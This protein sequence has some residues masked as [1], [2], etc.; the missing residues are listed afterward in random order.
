MVD[1]TP[2]IERVQP[3][4]TQ[5]SYKQTSPFKFWANKVIPLVYDDSL[6]YYEV[7]CKLTDYLNVVIDVVTDEERNIG[8]LNNAYHDLQEGVNDNVISL[9]NAY[10]QLQDY[11]NNYFDN[12][13]VQQEINNKL[14]EMASDGSLSSVVSPFIDAYKAE[15]NST[16]GGIN[17]EINALKSRVDTITALPE[18][19]TTADAEL[20]DIRDDSDGTKYT[21]AGNAVR[22]SFRALYNNLGFTDKGGIFLIVLCLLVV[23]I[24]FHLLSK[25]VALKQTVDYRFHRQLDAE[26]VTCY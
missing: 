21:T 3:D 14:D 23:S 1:F 8:E 22:G 4:Y 20:I 12:L 26:L 25:W 13:E 15:I 11:V 19:S 9:L 16:L 18:G 17:T 2:E 5:Y 24:M 6:S 10:N 7:L